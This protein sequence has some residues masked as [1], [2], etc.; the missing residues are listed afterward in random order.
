[1][2]THRMKLFVLFLTVKASVL[3]MKYNAQTHATNRLN[4]NEKPSNAN[5]IFV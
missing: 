5:N 2:I 1:M 4:S 3:Q